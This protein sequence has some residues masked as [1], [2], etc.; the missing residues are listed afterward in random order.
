MP[1]IHVDPTHCPQKSHL[2]ESSAKPHLVSLCLQGLVQAAI[3]DTLSTCLACV[4]DTGLSPHPRG[5]IRPTSTYKCECC[6]PVLGGVLHLQHALQEPEP[7]TSVVFDSITPLNTKIILE[8]IQ[9]VQDRRA[10]QW[11][12][13]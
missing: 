2:S 12:F 10:G 4:E 7:G 13:H 9:M 5:H 11:E 8:D 6:H 3:S 1:V